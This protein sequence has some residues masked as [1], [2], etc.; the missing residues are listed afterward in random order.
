MVTSLSS[1]RTDHLTS[2]QI[3]IHVFR[4]LNGRSRDVYP[5]P[6]SIAHFILKT[7]VKITNI[8]EFAFTI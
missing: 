3:V 8:V 1:S 2:I 5:L 6:V 4:Q 7:W